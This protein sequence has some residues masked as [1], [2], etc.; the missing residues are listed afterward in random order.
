MVEA[1]HSNGSGWSFLPL[2]K[3]L[4]GVW[5]SIVSVINNPVAGRSRLRN[6]FRGSVGNGEQLLFWL[7]PWLRDVPLMEAFPNLYRLES[8]KKC[9]VRD[10]LSGVW[11]WKHDPVLENEVIELDSLTAEVAAV[12]LMNRPDE[13]KWLPDNSGSFSVHSVKTLLDG[14]V[15]S[16]N[17]FVI[18]WCKWVPSKCNVFI[19]RAELNR[20]PTA[21]SLRKRGIQKVSRWCGLAPIYAFS[22]ADLL[23]VHNHKSV[24]A[25][26]KKVVHGIMFISIFSIWCLWLAR[27]KVVFSNVDAKV[28]SI[29][30]EVRSL[31]F[32]M[33]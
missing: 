10:R 13:W 25:E 28:D 11:L 6:L 14:A 24:R 33:V 4:G 5:S 20:I 8:V 17:R 7:D 12:S 16:N 2:K 32:F 27:N 18:D 30:N 15:D 21:D 3:S 23:N 31:S 1:I 29:F 19:W 26:V 22:F 9:S